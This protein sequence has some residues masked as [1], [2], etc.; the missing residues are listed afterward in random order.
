M[1]E[2]SRAWEV[3]A[4]RL[5]AVADALTDEEVTRL[6]P[7]LA[8]RARATEKTASLFRPPRTG[9]V[10]QVAADWH[11]FVVGRRGVGKSMLLLNVARHAAVKGQ[12]AVYIDIETL[13]DNPYPDV[14]VRLLI[15]LA[16]ELDR[17]LREPH[18]PSRRRWRAR[19]RL[20]RLRVRLETL[21][22]DPQQAQYQLSDSTQSRRT[23]RRGASGKAALARST[24][25]VAGQASTDQENSQSAASGREATFIRTKL[26]GLQAEA[27]EFREVLRGAVQATG[28]RGALI[29]LDDFYFI[30][31]ENQP[32]V[33]TYLQQVVKNLGIWLKI[34]AVEHRLNEFE[35][36]NPPR[37]LQLTQDAGKVPMDVT[38]A[39][40]EHTR[41]FLEEI[42]SDVCAEAQVDM[43]MLVTEGARLR[44][45]TA[46]GGVPRDYVNLVTAALDRATRRTGEQNRPRNRI[47]AEDVNLAAPEFLK[48][49][50]DDLRV[51]ARP[52][53]IDRLRNRLYD[54]LNFCLVHRK[55]NIFTVEARMLREA[56]WGRDIAALSD[57][58][59]FHRF[60]NLTVKSSDPGFVG[61]RYEGFAV[62]LSAYAATRVRTNE[63]EFWTTDGFQRSR[64]V[65]FV[66]T[67][68]VSNQVAKAPQ[69]RPPKGQPIVEIT[70]GQITIFD[71]LDDVAEES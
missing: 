15:E 20:A 39:D 48:Q 43:E 9:I 3:P 41:T 59:F 1:S 17:K 53:D 34:G 46:S 18:W 7:T 69:K 44:L 22:R 32:D 28:D 49:K 21:L 31:R 56:Q 29:I 26:E 16:G 70:P 47:T 63:V 64:G 52:E 24:A 6:L 68:E 12:P 35:D 50:E 38:L 8:A 11:H 10:E 61:Q 37:G 36:G 30:R 60:G 54:V 42:L 4:R 58:R 27:T 5:A 14:L 13:R 19:R 45:V 67:P 55:T 33:L 25:S 65:S 2:V 62:D 51:D 71:A 66:Y 40:F 57:L 23:R